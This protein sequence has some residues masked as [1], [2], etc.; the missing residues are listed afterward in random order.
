MV[1]WVKELEP[2]RPPA[3][4]GLVSV[5]GDAVIMPAP[6]AYDAGGPVCALGDVVAGLAA[7]ASA[8]AAQF[9]AVLVIVQ[10]DGG[11][12]GASESEPE[13]EAAGFHN[14]SEFYDGLPQ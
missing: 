4:W 3:S 12:E 13:L 14:P 6:P 11:S 7:E 5:G 2:T 10:R 8:V 9:G 1:P